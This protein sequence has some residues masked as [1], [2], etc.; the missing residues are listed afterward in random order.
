LGRPPD[1]DLARRPP[2]LEFSDIAMQYFYATMA[3]AKPSPHRRRIVAA[4]SP[5]R[6]RTVAAPSPRH[7]LPRRMQNPGLP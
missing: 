1:G 2:A 4:S 3:A 7:R 6:R 5:H